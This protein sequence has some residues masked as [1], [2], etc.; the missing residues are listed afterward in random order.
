MRADDPTQGARRHLTDEELD[1]YIMTRLALIGVDLSVLPEDDESAPVDRQ[2]VLRSARRFLREDIRRL[3][4][5]S[6]DSFGD[7]PALYPAALVRHTDR[8]AG[9]AR[10]D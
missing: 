7:P 1:Q 3:S 6:L 8:G 2:R 9:G 5:Y 10:S 4:E